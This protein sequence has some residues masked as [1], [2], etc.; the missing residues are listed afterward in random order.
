MRDGV[1][2]QLPTEEYR[3]AA[4]RMAG[5][6]VD[7]PAV[8]V[9][10]LDAEAVE[11]L[12]RARELRGNPLGAP[13]EVRDAPWVEAAAVPRDRPPHRAQLAAE[14]EELPPP[15]DEPLH[16]RAH[17]LERRVR[18][19]R[20]EEAHLGIVPPAV[21]RRRLLL[22]A[23]L[24]A[25]GTAGCGERDEPLGELAQPFPV[26]VQ[27]VGDQPTIVGEAP[28]RIVALDLGSARLLRALGAGA[29]L[30]GVP[31]T[32]RGQGRGQEVVDRAGQVDV[33]GIVRLEPDLIVAAPAVDTLDVAL[34]QRE[35]DAALYVQPDASVED[36]LRGTRDLGFLVGEPVRAR[37]LVA[38]MRRQVERVQAR[39]AGEPLVT[40]FVDTGF[41]ITIRERS[42][43]G[44]LIRR[45]RGES[46]AGAA[47]G[48]EPFPL[49]ELRR[50]DPDVYLATSESRVTLPT[51]RGDSR[52]ADLTAVEEG[53]VDVVPAD[54][55]LRPGPL[56]GR[57]LARVA[58][59]LHPDALG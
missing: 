26:T 35:T 33:E 27:G 39:V 28:R 46:V 2:A 44:D 58:R 57:A 29:R 30:V 55:V 50:L 49:A 16:E 20:R 8:E 48:P 22:V 43:L 53:R 6:K 59:A 25:L 52:T 34:A 1:L 4:L 42:L 24:G 10:H 13:L 21:P 54:L 3:L 5:G 51:L 7:E 14:T 37:R 23:V 11:L 18:L 12:D 31:A 17:D 47:P 19:F 40:V 9:L 38:T 56:V 36:L 32:R 41:F 15:P 45:A